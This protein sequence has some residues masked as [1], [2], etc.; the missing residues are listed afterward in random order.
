MTPTTANPFSL[1][2]R[3]ALVIG[4]T[5]GIGKA[6]AA[7]FARAGARVIVA[8]RDAAKL[9]RAVAALKAIGDAHGYTCDAT[10]LAALR[11]LVGVTLAH[12]GHIDILVNSQGVIRLKPAEEFTLEDW[13]E[14]MPTNLR[15]VF[16][17]CTEVGRHM[18]ARGRG[19]IISLASLASYR[20]WPRSALYGISK[21]GV[22]SLTETLGAEW[23]SRGVRVNA[24]APGFVMTDLN[25]DKMPPERKA[26]A[27]ARTPMGRFGE[28]DDLAGAAIYLASDAS[29]YVT[30]E[31]IRVDGGFLAAGL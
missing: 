14:V 29:A 22:V 2:G 20:G 26:L 27:L 13:N 31:T 4:G 1:E 16:F 12:H 24:I 8:G 28:T 5:A 9:E 25:R 17:A 23:A 10:D 21:A 6:I 18:L 19:S 11:G 30:G 15:S 7:G 3:H